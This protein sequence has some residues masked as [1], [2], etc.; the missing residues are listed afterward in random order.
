MQI[1]LRALRYFIAAAEAGSVSE[2]ASNLNLSQPS[3][4]TAIMQ[5]EEDLNIQLFVRLPSKGIRLTPQ[6]SEVLKEARQL[7]ATVEEFRASVDAVSGQMQG[8]L[9]FASFLNLGSSYMSDIIKSFQDQYPNINVQMKDYNQQEIFDALLTGKVEMAMTFDL[10]LPPVFDVRYVA[11]K[12]PFAVLPFGDP[13]ASQ[14]SVSIE[15]LAAR[16]FILMDLPHTAEYFQSLFQNMGLAPNI[17]YRTR[18]FETVRTFVAS[19][20]GV[21]ILNLKPGI[22]STY[23]RKKVVI[24]PIKQRLRP[25]KIVLLQYKRLRSRKIAET[26]ANH[27]SDYFAQTP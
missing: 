24:R 19:G 25:L 3:I 11:T 22:D 2:A 5:I 8:D 15:D 21:S 26:F 18:T 17:R 10:N 6:G 14:E 13:L 1:R 16:P 20:L 12:E 7:I 9:S 27:I 4:S 23:N